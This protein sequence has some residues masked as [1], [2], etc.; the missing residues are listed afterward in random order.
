[1]DWCRPSPGDWLLYTIEFTNVS[2]PGSGLAIV[3]PV[4]L[5]QLPEYV[6]VDSKNVAVTSSGGGVNVETT[7]DSTTNRLVIKD[8]EELLPAK[9]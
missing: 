6:A 4:I 1:M 3:N 8:T 7:M 2:D 5:D 9:A